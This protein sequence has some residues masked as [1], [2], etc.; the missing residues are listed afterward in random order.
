MKKWKQHAYANCTM[1]QCEKSGVKATSTRT[2]IGYSILYV[3]QMKWLRHYRLL[4]FGLLFRIRYIV[5]YWELR[6]L[7][8][9]LRFPK[10]RSKLSFFNARLES[11]HTL[12]FIAKKNNGTCFT[13]KKFFFLDMPMLIVTATL[14]QV[15]HKSCHILNCKL[16]DMP[17]ICSV[18][19]ACEWIQTTKLLLQLWNYFILCSQTVVIL[20]YRLHC[21]LLFMPYKYIWYMFHWLFNVYVHCALIV[22][23]PFEIAN[24]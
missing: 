22:S 21:G 2:I 9:T 16:N 6:I 10:Q 17:L 18:Q 11:V 5:R 24:E 20:V 14:C 12:T 7:L 8:V 4:Q 23:R 1:N 15:A 19:C 13:E 3:M